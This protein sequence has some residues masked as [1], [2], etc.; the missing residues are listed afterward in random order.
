[1]TGGL[2]PLSLSEAYWWKQ[3]S[4]I[5]SRHNQKQESGRSLSRIVLGRD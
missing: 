5:E 4:K 1:M 3:G 2:N